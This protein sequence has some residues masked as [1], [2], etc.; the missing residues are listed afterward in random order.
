MRNTE[1]HRSRATW[2]GCIIVSTLPDMADAG[3]PAQAD[4]RDGSASWHL[5]FTGCFEVDGV[6]Y[7]PASPYPGSPGSRLPDPDPNEAQVLPR[8]QQIMKAARTGAASVRAAD[9]TGDRRGPRAAL[10]PS[11]KICRIV[12]ISGQAAD[13]AVVTWVRLLT[14]PAHGACRGR[15]IPVRRPVRLVVAPP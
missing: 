5:G 11:L 8:G 6:R 9:S 15:T 4:C 2:T 3:L 12:A 1:S 14:R 13:R 7:G 10:T